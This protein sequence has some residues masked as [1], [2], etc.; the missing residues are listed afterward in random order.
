M[1]KYQFG[2]TPRPSKSP[3]HV[4]LQQGTCLIIDHE[5]LA[6]QGDNALSS[7]R[8]S[9]FLTLYYFCLIPHTT[10]EDIRGSALWSA[11][12]SSKSH[13]KSRVFVCVS[14]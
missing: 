11:A 3:M 2:Q 4:V 12:K 7:I 13:Y 5:A 10:Y 6:K 14:V 8:L 1:N 9:V